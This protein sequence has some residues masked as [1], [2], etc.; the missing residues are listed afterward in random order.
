MKY[1]KILL[2]GGTGQVGYELQ[3]YLKE[4]GDIWAPEREEFNLIEPEALRSKIRSFKP[5][6]IVNAAAFTA[7]ESAESELKPH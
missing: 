4:L 2:T 7:V 1:P 3:N 5:N 6:L